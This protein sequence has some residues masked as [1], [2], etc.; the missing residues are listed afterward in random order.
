MQKIVVLA[1]NENV[2]VLEES[3]CLSW[4]FNVDALDQGE[5]HLTLGMLQNLPI[6]K[7][8]RCEQSQVKTFFGIDIS[9]NN[10]STF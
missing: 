9:L 1:R 5:N 7:S 10:A 2:N 8:N 3:R 6:L 4:H